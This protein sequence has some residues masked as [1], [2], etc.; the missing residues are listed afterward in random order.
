M[1]NDSSN[2][3][4]HGT[5][6]KTLAKMDK[7]VSTTFLCQSAVI[8]TIF[9]LLTLISPGELR[10]SECLCILPAFTATAI[11]GLSIG[12]L[13]ANFFIG[14]SILDIVFGSLATLIGTI[15]TYFLRKYRW[16]MPLPPIIANTAIIPFVLKY[17]YGTTEAMPV[18]FAMIVISE[19]ICV[20]IFGQLLYQVL[21]KNSH[22]LFS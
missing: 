6:K 22:R 4:S 21:Y 11:P 5:S 3:L 2:G 16:L 10:F 20:Y 14:A 13:L 1:K 8:A 9:V 18:L 15:G 17:A 12:C 19:I 7:G